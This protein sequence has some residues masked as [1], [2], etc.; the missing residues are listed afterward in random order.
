MRAEP[1]HGAV[2]VCASIIWAVIHGHTRHKQTGRQAGRQAGRQTGRQA[3]RQTDRQTHTH[4]HSDRQTDRQTH[5]HTHTQTDRQT[6][7]HTQTYPVVWCSKAS[8]RC[9]LAGLMGWEPK[10]PPLTCV[11]CRVVLVVAAPL[12]PLLLLLIV[13]G[14]SV[15][16]I[17]AKE[18]VLKHLALLVREGGVAKSKVPAVHGLKKL[19]SCRVRGAAH[20]WRRRGKEMEGKEARGKGGGNK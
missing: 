18:R 17:K 14:S 8:W 5:T 10:R 13:I 16:L 11:L 15:C 3:G 4:T 2:S 20:A 19:C 6:H 9:W 12:L 7:R 1:G